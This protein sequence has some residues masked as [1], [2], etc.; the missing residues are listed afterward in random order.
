VSRFSIQLARAAIRELDRL[1]AAVRDQI[2]GDIED[3]AKAPI[4]RPPRIKRLRGY[5]GPFYRL[6]SGDFRVIYRV[7]GELVTVLSVMNRRDLER[8]LKQLGIT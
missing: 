4:G 3:L 7:D 1:P 6:R 5:T 8:A 2:V